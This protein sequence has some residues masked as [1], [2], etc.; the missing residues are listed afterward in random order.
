MHIYIHIHTYIYATKPGALLQPGRYVSCVCALE[1]HP[2]VAL[3]T[4]LDMSILLHYI[5]LLYLCIWRYCC[6]YYYILYYVIPYY[7]ILHYILDYAALGYARLRYWLASY[8]MCYVMLSYDAV[9]YIRL[10]TKL[11]LVTGYALLRPIFVLRIFKFGVW[12]KRNIKKE[13][14]DFLSAPS[15]FWAQWSHNSTQIFL[16]WEFL[17]WKLAVQLRTLEARPVNSMA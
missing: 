9:R 1:A 11:I 15:N 3:Y 10:H 14:E 13:V 5:I 7:S 12:A 4:R 17:V 2:H 8:V 6:T 16:V